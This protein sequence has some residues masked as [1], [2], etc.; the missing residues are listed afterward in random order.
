MFSNYIFKKRESLCSPTYM[1]MRKSLSEELYNSKG[2]NSIIKSHARVWAKVKLERALENKT[3]KL[4]QTP[5]RRLLRKNL[6]SHE[7]IFWEKLSS[8]TFRSKA[9][10]PFISLL[11][12]LYSLYY[13][14]NIFI[15]MSSTFCT[16][17]LSF[18][19][20]LL[21][22]LKNFFQGRLLPHFWFLYSNFSQFFFVS[23]I[24]CPRFL[25]N[26][27][28]K[29]FPFEWFNRSQFKPR[30]ESS[31]HAYPSAYPFLKFYLVIQP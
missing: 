9:M 10:K 31:I 17:I 7:N 2:I 30:T 22:F 8:K 24:T 13:I 3:V 19:F 4:C 29:G 18:A 6:C 28:V 11:L 15:H 25:S 12:V 26:A 23:F 14:H 16:R 5:N 21:I 20:L 1:K 27:I